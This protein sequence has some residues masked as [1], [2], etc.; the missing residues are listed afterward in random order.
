[1]GSSN[2]TSTFYS[3]SSVGAVNT[4][5]DSGFDSNLDMKMPSEDD[6]FGFSFES[7]PS[8]LVNLA[9]EAVDNTKTTTRSAQSSYDLLPLLLAKLAG[10][11]ESSSML[12]QEDS[13]T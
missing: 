2:S 9:A 12:D 8:S 7:S 4:R 11:S 6:L 13:S 5:M 10:K 1:M 3:T